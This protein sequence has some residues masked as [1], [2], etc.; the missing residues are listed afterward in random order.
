MAAEF[1]FLAQQAIGLSSSS[2]SSRWRESGGGGIPA[3]LRV[4][5]QWGVVFVGIV[6]GVAAA[7][8][9]WLLLWWWLARCGNRS[10]GR[11]SRIPTTLVRRGPTDSIL[12]PTS[13]NEPVAEVEVVV[14]EVVLYPHLAARQEFHTALILLR[15]WVSPEHRHGPCHAAAAAV[16]RT[17]D[18]FTLEINETETESEVSLSHSHSHTI[19]LTQSL[20]HNRTNTTPSVV[21]G[22]WI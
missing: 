20:S 21:D 3:F 11:I 16:A 13:N 7:V 17:N 14:V 4:E 12:M 18:W 1:S 22:I 6:E 9:Q 8:E 15:V 10:T 5:Y 19:T 2:S